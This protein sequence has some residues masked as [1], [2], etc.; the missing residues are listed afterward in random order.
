MTKT[1]KQ[2]QE[3]QV[4]NPTLNEPV[5]LN[6]SIGV[7]ET[8]TTTPT[9]KPTNMINQIK[10]YTNGSTYRLYWYDVKNNVWHYVTA[11]A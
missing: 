4:D 6:N 3:V 5:F 9:G 10:I 1:Y 7:F 2:P 8:V 11:T